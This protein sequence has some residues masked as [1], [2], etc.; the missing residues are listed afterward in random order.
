MPPCCEPCC[1]RTADCRTLARALP[2]AIDRQ[3]MARVWR[4]GQTKDVHIYRFLSTGSIEE[5]MYQR[6][7][8]KV[9]ACAHPRAVMWWMSRADELFV[10]VATVQEEVATA[11]VDED[12]GAHRN[13]VRD[14]LKDVFKFDSKDQDQCGTFRLVTDARTARARQQRIPAAMAAGAGA[15]AGAGAVHSAPKASDGWDYDGAAS[16]RDVVLRTALEASTLEDAGASGESATGGAC[17]A[18]TACIVTYVRQQ[19][20]GDGC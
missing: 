20:F 11:V 8:L 18:D 3:A 14:D 7:I 9:R 12:L 5:K 19:R 6:Q 1:C 10:P 15:G 4:D 16:V 17:G 13:F 2:P